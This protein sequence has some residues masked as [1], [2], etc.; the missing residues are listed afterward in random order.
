MRWTVGRLVTTG[1]VLGLAL[2]ATR[3]DPPMPSPPDALAPAAGRYLIATPE[4]RGAIFHESVIFLVSY[5]PGGAMGLIVNRPTELTMSE[6]FESAAPKGKPF[7]VGGPV[8][9]RSVM[10]LLRAESPPEMAMHVSGDVFLTANEA[11]MVENSLRPDASQRMRA[12]L[13]YSGWSP[14]Q[15]DGEIARGQ[16]IVVRAPTGLIFDEEPAGLWERLYEQ[17]HR[18]VT[19]LMRPR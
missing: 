10:A 7:F 5:G 12:Y 16:W 8:E 1:I 17:H 9:R 13:G 3:P 19:R 18:V 11:L 15:L 6:V 2:G 14:A 4:I